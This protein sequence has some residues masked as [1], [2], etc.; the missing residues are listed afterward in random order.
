MVILAWNQIWGT[1]IGHSKDSED[2]RRKRN[3]GVFEH[4]EKDSHQ[5]QTCQDDGI[6][7]IF[8]E[9]EISLQSTI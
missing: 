4:Y 3:A 5:G 8:N 7:L 9:I 1:Q 6:S 2:P